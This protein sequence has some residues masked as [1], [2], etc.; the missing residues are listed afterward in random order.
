[1]KDC[2]REVALEFSIIVLYHSR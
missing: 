1:M 2:Y